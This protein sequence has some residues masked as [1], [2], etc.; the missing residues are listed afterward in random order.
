MK[1][2]GV[3]EDHSCYDFDRQENINS[4]ASQ[5]QNE[6]EKHHGKKNN[7]VSRAYDN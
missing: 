2:G 6:K 1:W 4:R 3:G 5:K 7:L